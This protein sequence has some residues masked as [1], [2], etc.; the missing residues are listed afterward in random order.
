MWLRV[1]TSQKVVIYSDGDNSIIIHYCYWGF[2]FKLVLRWL[3]WYYVGITLVALVALVFRWL[4]WYFAGS[5]GISSV[6]ILSL[7][8]D[9]K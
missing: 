9:G 2:W 6:V 3:R 5:I 7:K 1:L 8:V 4:R